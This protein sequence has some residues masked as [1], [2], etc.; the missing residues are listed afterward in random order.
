MTTDAS[1]LAKDIRRFIPPDVI[2]NDPAIKVRV[3][4]KVRT[5]WALLLAADEAQRKARA[6]MDSWRDE[7]PYMVL[8]AMHDMAAEMQAA[9]KAQVNGQ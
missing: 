6:A 9:A 5:A 8:V 7:N 3:A 1:Q 2:A 4:A